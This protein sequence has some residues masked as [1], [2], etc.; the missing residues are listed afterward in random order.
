[1]AS[2]STATGSKHTHIKELEKFYADFLD[3][4]GPLKKKS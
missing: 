3:T 2:A 4:S 1:M